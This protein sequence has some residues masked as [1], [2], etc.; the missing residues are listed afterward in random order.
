MFSFSSLS[1]HIMKHSYKQC[2]VHLIMTRTTSVGDCRI[3]KFNHQLQIKMYLTV[4]GNKISSAHYECTFI[5]DR[6]QYSAFQWWTE[7]QDAEWFVSYQHNRES[8][9]ATSYSN[10]YKWKQYQ[11]IYSRCHSLPI[12]IKLTCSTFYCDLNRYHEWTV[13]IMIN[14]Y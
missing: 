2:C 13:V 1:M 9:Q 14:H 8:F 5:S 4:H 11:Q 10:S 3:S 12:T 6:H 7:F